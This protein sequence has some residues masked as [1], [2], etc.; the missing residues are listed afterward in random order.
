M[1]TEEKV[2]FA[3]ETAF[4]RILCHPKLPATAKLS[5]I[6]GLIQFATFLRADGE[7]I[8]LAD[9]YSEKLKA[10]NAGVMHEDLKFLLTLPLP[11]L[12]DSVF[13]PD[14]L[15]DVFEEKI[16]RFLSTA[17]SIK[18]KGGHDGETD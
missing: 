13:V 8:E 14:E 18:S 2:M 15:N 5:G 11:K 4:F 6:M 16:A 12:G 17:E 9:H 7:G 10:A 1:T 3:W